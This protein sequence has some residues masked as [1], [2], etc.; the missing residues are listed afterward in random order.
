[1]DSPTIKPFVIRGRP[2]DTPASRF[3]SVV[4]K[5][6]LLNVV[7]VLTSF[8]VLVLGGGPN[9]VIPALV[10]M[11]AITVLIWSATLVVASCVSLGLVLW[12][13][14]KSRARRKPPRPTREAGM[15][16]RWLDAPA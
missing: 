15:A 4:R 8:P 2:D 1:M 3:R 9:A 14:S 11:A 16:D 10:I 12:T 6:A 5:S 13:A 7:I